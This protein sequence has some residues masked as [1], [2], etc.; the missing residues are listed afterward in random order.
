MQFKLINKVFFYEKLLNIRYTVYSI[1]L[2]NLEFVNVRCLEN[3]NLHL[4]F[5]NNNNQLRNKMKPTLSLISSLSLN[6]KTSVYSMI[7]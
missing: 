1:V 7:N 2:Y 3:C 6:F 5:L 4:R